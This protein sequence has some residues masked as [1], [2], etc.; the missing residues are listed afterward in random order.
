MESQNIMGGVGALLYHDQV[1]D[2]S[3]LKLRISNGMA[4]GSWEGYIT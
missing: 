4:N 2:K 1:T 3:F